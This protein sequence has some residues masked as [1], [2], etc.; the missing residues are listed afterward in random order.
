[1]NNQVNS[2][3]WGNSGP[4]SGAGVDEDDGGWG[5]GPPGVGSGWMGN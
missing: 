1:M 3:G 2:G 4:M 5:V